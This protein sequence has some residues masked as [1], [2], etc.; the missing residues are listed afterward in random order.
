MLALSLPVPS[1]SLRVGPSQKG[2]ESVTCAVPFYAFISISF[3]PVF[4]PEG[5]GPKGRDRRERKEDKGTKRSA[6]LNYNNTKQN[7]IIGSVPFVFLARKVLFSI[8]FYSFYLQFFIFQ[9]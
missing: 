5:S 2:R 8:I 7:K 9:S 3:I 4:L 1:L 6:E